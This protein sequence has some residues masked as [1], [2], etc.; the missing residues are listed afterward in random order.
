MYSKYLVLCNTC[1]DSFVKCPMKAG[2]SRQSFQLV[3]E[4]EM[5]SQPLS[6]LITQRTD[7]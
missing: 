7:A 6:V 5:K 4:P 2:Y 1:F 3:R